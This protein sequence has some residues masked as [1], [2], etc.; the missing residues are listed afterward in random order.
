MPTVFVINGF[1]FFFYSNENDE[2][3]HIHVEKAEDAAKFWL[4]PV[5]L[6]Y[7]YGFSSRELKQIENIVKQNSNTLIAKWNEYFNK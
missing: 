5:K 7:N 4:N 3:V 6:E 1:R 2:P